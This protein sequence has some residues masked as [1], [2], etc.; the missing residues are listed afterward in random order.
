M[1]RMMDLAPADPEEHQQTEV[2]TPP[3]IG[4]KTEAEAAYTCPMH[5]E[6]RSLTPGRC[7]RCGIALEHER[8]G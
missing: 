6:V 3:D 8:T 7:P 5:P 2:A 4:E 1:L